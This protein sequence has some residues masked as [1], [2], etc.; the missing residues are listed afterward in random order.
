MA[1]QQNSQNPV[2]NILRIYNKDVSLETPNSPE[3]FK[4]EWKPETKLDLDITNKLI[5]D[6]VYDVTL[7]ITVTVK[8][9]EKVAF[10]CEVNQA[11]LFQIQNIPEEQLDGF[12]NAFVPNILYPYAREVISSLVNKATFPAL[13]LAPINFDALYA[14]RKAHEAEQK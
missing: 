14:Q 9:A 11:G 13:N 4:A 10:L 6:S 8:I 1:E 7:R 3:I 2:F 12:L 5:E